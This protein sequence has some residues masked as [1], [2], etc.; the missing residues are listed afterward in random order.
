MQEEDTEE[1]NYILPDSLDKKLARSKLGTGMQF[2]KKK[3]LGI[4]FFVRFSLRI[5]YSFFFCK[6]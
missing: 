3:N 1:D 5:F 2:Y 4:F 6:L